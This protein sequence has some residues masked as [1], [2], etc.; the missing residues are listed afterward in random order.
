M[1]YNKIYYD[2]FKY[3]YLYLIINKYRWKK[4]FGFLEATRVITVLF[5]CYDDIF[6]KTKIE[7]CYILIYGNFEYYQSIFDMPWIKLLLFY[8]IW[9]CE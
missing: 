3:N 6:Q 8:Y 4:T 1:I 7:N 9:I 2:F 5:L